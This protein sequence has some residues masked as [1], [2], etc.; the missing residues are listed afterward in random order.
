MSISQIQFLS[1]AGV[2]INHFNFFMDSINTD[3]IMV[4][5]LGSLFSPN[6]EQIIIFSLSRCVISPIDVISGS[7]GLL[8]STDTRASHQV[9]ISTDPSYGR[10]WPHPHS[11]G[12]TSLM[13]PYNL[14]CQ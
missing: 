8:P 7:V 10:L 9:M 1:R 6:R 13:K 2:K 11:L 5:T 14:L 4:I 12:L 3:G